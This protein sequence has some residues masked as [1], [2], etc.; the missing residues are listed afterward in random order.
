MI[1]YLTPVYFSIW[2][3]YG[4]LVDLY[5]FALDQFRALIRITG[6]NSE[7]LLIILSNFLHLS[8]RRLLYLMRGVEYK[9]SNDPKVSQPSVCEVVWGYVQT[10]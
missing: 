9:M 3:D 10:I 5:T 1:L 8:S 6:M 2:T 7:R 4:P